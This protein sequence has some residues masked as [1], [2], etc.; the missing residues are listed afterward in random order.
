M[1]ALYEKLDEGNCFCAGVTE[2][3][4]FAGG[5]R[6]WLLGVNAWYHGYEVEEV[7]RSDRVFANSHTQHPYITFGG[8]VTRSLL[9]YYMAA[10]A[11]GSIPGL[12][13][14]IRGLSGKL[15]TFPVLRSIGQDHLT[16]IIGAT[17]IETGI[18]TFPGIVSD[19]RNGEGADNVFRNAGLDIGR[20][21]LFNIGEEASSV[22]VGKEQPMI[23]RRKGEFT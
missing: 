9:T 7:Y 17:L 18:S 16:N 1:S 11:A 22:D 23:E 5:Y 10:E 20:N 12:A 4:P 14:R 6:N 19:I 3:G 13:G 21:L 2:G 8:D 15:S